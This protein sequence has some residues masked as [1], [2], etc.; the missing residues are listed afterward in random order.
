MPLE[1]TDT[2]EFNIPKAVDDVIS[3]AIPHP[4]ISPVTEMS[5][6]LVNVNSP[7]ELKALIVTIPVI[8]AI[9]FGSAGFVRGITVL[10][11]VVEE[12]NP[13]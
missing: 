13:G 5:A 1:P 11:V 3:T 4:V 8:L 12:R 6:I 9:K 10:A 2:T 7:E